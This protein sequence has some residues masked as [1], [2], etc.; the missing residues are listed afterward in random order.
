MSP[1][2]IG[3]DVEPTLIRFSA[4]VTPG[5]TK[6]RAMPSAIAPKIHTVR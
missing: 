3:M 1:I 6:P 5:A 4:A 2:A